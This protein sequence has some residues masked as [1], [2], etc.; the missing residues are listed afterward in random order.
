MK[1]GLFLVV[2]LL[3]PGSTG[4]MCCINNVYTSVA[5]V[6]VKGHLIAVCMSIN[7]FGYI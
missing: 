4:I 3:R 5:G 1:G 7:R 6:P 2:I